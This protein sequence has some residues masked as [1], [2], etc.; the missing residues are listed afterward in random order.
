MFLKF[1]IGTNSANP[2]NLQWNYKPL[3]LLLKENSIWTEWAMASLIY[4]SLGPKKSQLLI[5]SALC[6]YKA[7][8]TTTTEKDGEKYCCLLSLTNSSR[9]MLRIGS[10]LYFKE[11]GSRNYINLKRMLELVTKQAWLLLLHSGIKSSVRKRIC[12]LV[13][14][15]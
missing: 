7:T 1:L 3:F 10:F 6:I 14:A 11:L 2:S 13:M 5:N 15:F 4:L 9:K 12:I 8:T